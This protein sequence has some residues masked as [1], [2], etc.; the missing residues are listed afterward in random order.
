MYTPLEDSQNV[1]SP[2]LKINLG[3]A[4]AL[5]GPTEGEKKGR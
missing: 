5:T 4:T 1:E 3:H 2:P